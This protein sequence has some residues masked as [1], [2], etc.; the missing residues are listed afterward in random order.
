MSSRLQLFVLLR[1]FLRLFLRGRPRSE[2]AAARTGLAGRFALMMIVHACVGGVALLFWWLGPF[3]MS[4]SLHAMTFLMVGMMLASS[5]GTLLFNAEEADILLHRPVVPRVLLAAKVSVLIAVG[6]ALAL[7]LNLTGFA[8][9]IF[10][11]NGTWLYLPVHLVTLAFEVTFAA[12]LVTLAY[13]LCLRWFGREKLDNF[14]TTAQVIVAV[15]AMVGGQLVPHLLK[16]ADPLRMKSA[17]HWLVLL[18]PAWFGG[19]DALLTG[20]ESSI[21]VVVLAA[22]AVGMTA[23]VAWLAFTRL[24]GSYAEGLMALNEAGPAATKPGG[25]HG[26]VIRRVLR[27]PPVRFWLR[28]PVERAAFHLTA[29]E[30]ARA[31]DVKLRVYPQL[32]Q[33]AVFPLIFLVGTS[34]RRHFGSSIFSALPVSFVGAMLSTMIFSSIEMLRFSDH[35]RGAELFR[36]VPIESPARLFHGARKAMLLLLC[37]PLAIA[38]TLLMIVWKGVAGGALASPAWIHCDACIRPAPRHPPH[39]RPILRTP[40]THP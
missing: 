23:A 25:K 20:R 12:S 9:G 6:F 29:A 21:T 39:A 17:L 33:L 22:L 1:L 28:D 38:L 37:W 35:W 32:A 36:V 24:A 34:S 19:L 11:R 5:S 18:P 27:F 16:D 15:V 2:R 8:L 14:I 31:R 10:G 3:E 13:G 7:A 26:R 30:L 40:R 4:A